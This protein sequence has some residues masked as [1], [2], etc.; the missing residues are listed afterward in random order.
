MPLHLYG[1]CVCV[2]ACTHLLICPSAR[3]QPPGEG[4][5]TQRWFSAHMWVLWIELGPQ[6]RQ[7]LP[8]L[9]ESPHQSHTVMFMCVLWT[10]AYVATEP[11]SGSGLVNSIKLS[12]D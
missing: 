4:Q 8:L 6:A 1:V 11:S 12:S 3:F 5:D 9:A 10:G 2:R 7:P